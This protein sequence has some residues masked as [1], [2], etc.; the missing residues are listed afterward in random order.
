MFF[1]QAQMKVKWSQTDFKL[2]DTHGA[3]QRSGVTL[4]SEWESEQEPIKITLT[5]GD[6]MF[7]SGSYRKR[8]IW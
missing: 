4:L 8:D 2:A 7:L 1:S 5:F 6:I 3:A